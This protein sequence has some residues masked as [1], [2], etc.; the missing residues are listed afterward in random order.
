MEF[1]MN[2]LD[3]LDRANEIAVVGMACRVPGARNI[4]EFWQNLRAGVESVS[5]FSD[6]DLISAGIDP[7]IV[8]AH[9]YVKAGAI[10]EDIELFDASFFRFTP[11]EAEITDPQ[12]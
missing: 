1:K 4:D 2:N 9:N 12:H 6:E 7:T 11:R 5:F 10:V 8:R 3:A